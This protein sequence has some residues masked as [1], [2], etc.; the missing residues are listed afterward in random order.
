MEQPL[1]CPTDVQEFGKESGVSQQLLDQMGREQVEALL[2]GQLVAEAIAQGYQ[3]ADEY[4]ATVWVNPKNDYPMQPSEYP[5]GVL[6][7][8][9]I[10]HVLPQEAS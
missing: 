2:L 10:I 5:D 8:R 4:A 3:R 9:Q 6:V 1:S 7:A